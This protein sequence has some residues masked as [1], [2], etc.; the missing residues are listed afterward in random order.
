[1]DCLWVFDILPDGRL[2][3]ILGGE[4]EEESTELSVVIN[5]LTEIEK[6]IAEQSGL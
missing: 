4:E 2:L 5:R 6:R 1:M 3:M